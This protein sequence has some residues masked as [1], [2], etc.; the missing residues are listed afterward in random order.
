MGGRNTFTEPQYNPGL[1]NNVFEGTSVSTIGVMDPHGVGL[2]TGSSHYQKL[3]QNMANSL[4][5][6]Q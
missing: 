5:Q 3:I 1:V 4:S 2:A 6:C